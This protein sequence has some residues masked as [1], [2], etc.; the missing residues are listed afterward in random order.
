MKKKESSFI[1]FFDGYKAGNIAF[2]EPSLKVYKNNLINQIKNLI[3]II[4]ATNEPDKI[5]IFEKLIKSLEKNNN[6]NIYQYILIIE[7]IKLFIDTNDP[8][9][10]KTNDQLLQSIKKIIYDLLNVSEK[11]EDSELSSLVIEIAESFNEI[12]F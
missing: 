11:I 10:F 9:I 2:S 3:N 4:Q 1:G 7:A 12:I 6:E 8:E 5:L